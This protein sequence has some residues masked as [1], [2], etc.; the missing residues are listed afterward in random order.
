M[1]SPLRLMEAKCSSLQLYAAPVIV[2]EWPLN[3]FIH[4]FLCKSHILTTWPLP[5]EHIYLDTLLLKLRADI[6]SCING[7][8]RKR[9]NTLDYLV[10]THSFKHL[11]SH[12]TTPYLLQLYNYITSML[13]PLSVPA[14][15]IVPKLCPFLCHNDIFL[16]SPALTTTKSAKITTH[17]EQ[18]KAQFGIPE[19]SQ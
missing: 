6:D 2:L 1:R 13:S 10:S 17:I 3:H 9:S 15:G 8:T 18:Q 7:S 16:S 5:P 14:T 19:N 12:H 11:V 4:L